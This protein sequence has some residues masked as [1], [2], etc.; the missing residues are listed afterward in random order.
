MRSGY[1]AI[2]SMALHSAALDGGKIMSKKSDKIIPQKAGDQSKPSELNEQQL[3]MIAGGTTSTDKA[4][5]NLF[6]LTSTGTHIKEGK[7]T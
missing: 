5:P 3:D 1:V 2:A 4:S 7:I 6:K